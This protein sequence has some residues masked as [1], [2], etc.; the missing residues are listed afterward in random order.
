MRCT[1]RSVFRPKHA[2]CFAHWVGVVKLPPTPAG[3]RDRT[4]AGAVLTSKEVV[5]V[6]GPG[7]SIEVAATAPKICQRKV[8]RAEMLRDKGG[9]TYQRFRARE[10]G[11]V[12][13]H[14]ERNKK[15]RRAEDKKLSM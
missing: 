3:V 13:Q 7:S 14:R 8:A 4:Q 15:Q 2:S 5:V 6:R 11:F 9:V 1:G 10:A 12:A